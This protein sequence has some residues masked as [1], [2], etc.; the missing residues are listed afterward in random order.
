M[1]FRSTTVN[2]VY[3]MPDYSNIVQEFLWQTMD[4]PPKFQRV[5]SFLNYWHKNIDAMI[6][7][8][9]LSA[10]TKHPL[11]GNTFHNV[12]DIFCVGKNYHH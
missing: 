6:H 2:V 1:L 11:K 7:S 4:Q 5:H 3:Y 8:I 10:Q 12:T 9:F